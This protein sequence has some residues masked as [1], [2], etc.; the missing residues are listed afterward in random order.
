MLQLSPLIWQRAS[1]NSPSPTNIWRVVETQRLTRTQFQRWLP[2][3]H[4]AQHFGL[5]ADAVVQ[6]ARAL[7]HLPPR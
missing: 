4:L 1:S 6:R 3:Q 5:T 7:V 2:A